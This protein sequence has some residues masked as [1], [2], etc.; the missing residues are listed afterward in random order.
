[1]N[2]TWKLTLSLIVVVIGLAGVWFLIRSEQDRTPPEIIIE[3]K[4][5]IY[6][7]DMSSEELLNNIYAE[8]DRDGDVSNSL[9]IEKIYSDENGNVCVVYVAR[10]T[11]NN[12]AKIN[13]ILR[14]E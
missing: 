13:R 14:V 12:V 8:D 7:Y 1:M 6:D 4:S 11:S 5:D 2:K 3:S 9:R 10:D